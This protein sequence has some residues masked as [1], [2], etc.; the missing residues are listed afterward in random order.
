[1]IENAFS[2]AQISAGY[3][4]NRVLTDVSLSIPCG[5][6]TSILGTNGGGKSTLLRV[7]CG[8]I[9]A[10][11]GSLSILGHDSRRFS[12]RD[13]AKTI[14]F[15]PQNRVIPDCT[16]EQLLL[17]A[18]FPHKH[19]FSPYSALDKH[20]VHDIIEKQ[21]LQNIAQRPLAELSGG[22][23]QK[24]Y[25]AMAL[26]QNT[27][28]LLLDEPLSFLD[29]ACQFE[30][31]AIL[32]HLAASGRTIVLVSHDLPLALEHSD[33]IAILDRGKIAY[34]GSPDENAAEELTRVFSVRAYRVKLI[35]GT[36]RFVF[37]PHL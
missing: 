21:G 10:K 4:K 13:F 2:L 11:S 22:Q 12:R 16:V 1:M 36:F 3:A 23:R 14:A 31:L 34:S 6:I 25:I 32:Q 8:Q 15:V 35:D 28:I 27:P 24:A 9:K 5:K 20:T 19:F 26:C 29:I 7:L 30:I 17:C 18:R 37:S 33:K